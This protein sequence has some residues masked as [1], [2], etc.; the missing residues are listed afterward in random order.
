MRISKAFVA[1]ASFGMV[2][3]LG[4]QSVQTAQADTDP[5]IPILQAC[6]S[7]TDS[8]VSL[9]AAP[10]IGI[11]TKVP[12]TA[13]YLRLWDEQV[14][15]RNLFP[16]SNTPDPTAMKVL[17]DRLD[18]AHSSGAKA[19]YVMGLTPQWAAADPTAG[20]ARFGAGSASPPSNPEF[21]DN[22]VRTLV[23]TFGSRIDAYE[24]WNEGNIKTFW[25]GSAEQ[26]ADLTARAYSIIKAG[27]PSAIVLAPST[28][29]RLGNAM[30]VFVSGFINQAAKT[31]PS[32]A[33]DGFAIHSY[34][35][36]TGTAADRATLIKNWQTSLA[37]ALPDSANSVLERPIWDTEVN[38][39]LAGPGTTPA[40]DYTDAQ[41]AELLKQTYADSK[42]LG[43]DATFWYLYTA[44]PFD[45]LGVQFWSGTPAT[46]AAWNETRSKWATGTGVCSAPPAA[47]S[48]GSTS[49]TTGSTLVA[50]HFGPVVSVGFVTLS[51][52]LLP[53]TGSSTTIV[54][55][56]PG[57]CTQSTS[58]TA[59]TT[60]CGSSLIAPCTIGPN[61]TASNVQ[62]L[63]ARD[64]AP[65]LYVHVIDGLIHLTNDGGLQSFAAGQFGYTPNVQQPPVVLPLNPGMQFT[66]PP[67]FVS[68]TPIP[69]TTPAPTCSVTARA[70]DL[71]AKVSPTFAQGDVAMIQ[72]GGF[73]PGTTVSAYVGKNASS[74]ASLNTDAQGKISMW[75]RIP[76]SIP[77]GA[78]TIQLN[79]H[80][81]SKAL[82][83]ITSGVSVRAAQPHVV[84]GT[85]TM[86]AKQ[87]KLNAKERFALNKIAVQVPATVPAQCV[88]TTTPGNAK[89]IKKYFVKDGMQCT[90][91]PSAN[92]SQATVKVNFAN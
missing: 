11:G 77:I 61:S 8:F 21:F 50:Q 57:T 88:I 47:G 58:D 4:M 42:A 19:L 5:G 92:A 2:I 68:G 49:G 44:S 69:G 90:V 29:L 27:D 48:S 63:T 23:S 71:R 25:S 65:G 6:K 34:P 24:L 85:V 72:A 84:T 13:G 40:T 66:P 30:N 10:E 33:F 91:K 78:T 81:A 1:V 60:A 52:P 45:L 32:Y 38:Y 59:L 39:G 37:I 31:N 51:D 12:V 17:S 18:Q 67:S 26:L 73:A 20:D 87:K 80:L 46:I 75:V 3:G 56:Q 74:A 83:S 9:Q 64:L 15:W 16:S 86:D 62:Q 28:T 35:S 36:G 89:S 82:V 43:V 14:A 22:Y 7:T 79:G 53:L 55:N 54:G 41:G 76:A 70:G